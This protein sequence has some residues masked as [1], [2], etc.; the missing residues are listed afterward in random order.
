M[1]DRREVEAS[2]GQALAAQWACPFLEASAK[3]RVNVNE[4][5]AEVVRE[6]NA[7]YRPAKSSSGCCLLL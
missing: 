2:R 5:F 1:K 3:T 4:V 6:M 7:K